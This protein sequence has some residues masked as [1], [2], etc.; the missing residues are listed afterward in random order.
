MKLTL[1][2]LAIDD[3]HSTR[4]E[5]YATEREAHLAR[6]AAIAHTAEQEEAMTVLY[7]AGQ[8]DELLALIEELKPDEDTFN[9][10]RQELEVRGLTVVG[11][12]LALLS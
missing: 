7:D 12:G 8:T 5:V 3:D 1:W 4:A 2:T 11:P 9:V 10:E 6:F